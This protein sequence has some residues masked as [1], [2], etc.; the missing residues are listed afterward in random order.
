[1]ID[2]EGRELWRMTTN[3][4]VPF[5]LFAGQNQVNPFAIRMP[6]VDRE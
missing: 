1:M 4:R 2:N 6:T 3:S 5:G